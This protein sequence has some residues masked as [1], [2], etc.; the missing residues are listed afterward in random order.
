MVKNRLSSAELTNIVI[1]NATDPVK[2]FIYKYHVR[3]PGYA[4]Q[5]GK[6]L[7][8][9]AGYFVK[10]IEPLFSAGTRRLSVSEGFL[11]SF[12][13]SIWSSVNPELL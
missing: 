8:F 1:E 9:Q 10:G 12:S 7:F 13:F 3:V 6:R 11:L 4:Q 2:P 5:T